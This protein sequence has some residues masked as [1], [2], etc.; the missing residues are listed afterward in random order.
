VRI[1][2]TR[3]LGGLAPAH[4]ALV[5]ALRDPDWQVQASAARLL[6]DAQPAT[7]ATLHELLSSPHFH[8]RR[9][10]ALSLHSL[11]EPG[12]AA[13]RAALASSD[14]FARAISHFTLELPVVR[15]A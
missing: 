11:G 1:A 14:A 12:D 7:I 15:H 9:N 3:A 10:A 5:A 8:V 6:R 4:P 13:L 2:C